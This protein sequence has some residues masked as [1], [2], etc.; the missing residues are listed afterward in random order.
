M[1]NINETVVL[2]TG[3]S[4]GIGK[5]TAKQLLKEGYNLRL[6]QKQLGHSHIGTTQAYADV[7]EP[8]MQRALERLYNPVA[9]RVRNI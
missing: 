8:D 3:A 5:A 1:K 4:S 7:V 9:R 6:V 2:L